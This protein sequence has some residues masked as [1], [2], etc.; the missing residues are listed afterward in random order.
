MR[1]FSFITGY[2]DP[3]QEQFLNLTEF[4]SVNDFTTEPIDPAVVQAHESVLENIKNYEL[5]V[6]NPYR[7]LKTHL[8]WQ[9]IPNCKSIRNDGV[10]GSY[11]GKAWGK[12]TDFVSSVPLFESLETFDIEWAEFRKGIDAEN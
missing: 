12:F 7:S 5:N 6:Q 10:N 4:V 8:F 3:I 11:H 1:M 9:Y 2:V